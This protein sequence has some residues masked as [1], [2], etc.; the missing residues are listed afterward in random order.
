MPTYCY[1]RKDNG[2]L[3][4]MQM[5]VFEL[6][7]RQQKDGSIVLDDGGEAVRDYAEEMGGFRHCPGTYPM[8]SEALGVHPSQI[9]AFAKDAADKGI[10]TE[11]T[12]DGG[13]IFRD[14]THRREYCR[15]YGFFDKNAGYSDPTPK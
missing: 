6:V 13:V 10:P 9:P 8:I 5:S 14:R 12:R 1:R 3:V 11:F 15:A 2:E 7:R 4:E